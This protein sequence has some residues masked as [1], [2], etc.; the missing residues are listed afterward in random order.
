MKVLTASA[1]LLVCTIAGVMGQPCLTTE[2]L[3]LIKGFEGFRAKAYTDVAGVRTIGYGTLCRTG[4]LKCPGPVTEAAAAAELGRSVVANYA[5]CVRKYVKASMN[6][7]QYSAL[8]SFTYNLGC[9]SLQSM[10]KAAGGSL[11]NMPT[12]MVKYNKAVVNGRL[13]VVQGLVNRRA[14]EVSFFRSTAISACAKNARGAV[15]RSSAPIPVIASG[16]VGVPQPVGGNRVGI[17]VAPEFL[18][19]DSTPT[20][21]SV[22]PYSEVSVEWPKPDPVPGTDVTPHEPIP[23]EPPARKP[24]PVWSRV[25]FSKPALPPHTDGRIVVEGE[26]TG[27]VKWLKDGEVVYRS[28]PMVMGGLRK[29]KVERKT[30]KAKARAKMAAVAKAVAAVK[31]KK[32]ERRATRRTARKARRAARKAKREASKKAHF[33][34]IAKQK[35]DRK[36]ARKTRK[37]DARKARK[38]SSPVRHAKKAAES[39]KLAAEQAARH[40]AEVRKAAE[41]AMKIAEDA[42]RK[43]EKAERRKKKRRSG[44]SARPVM[45]S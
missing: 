26:D 4:T 43:K 30:L 29:T 38:D 25:K 37:A 22:S 19:P 34:E 32:T 6:S 36:A 45:S 33:E 2:G 16:P 27:S 31:A 44:R 10:V 24:F 1:V 12:H 18:P 42:K 7:N 11:A 39:A 21:S 40:K 8:I 9:G 35:A 15:L 41:H 13:Q 28:K 5:P 14:K 3:N 17:P 23:L 20:P